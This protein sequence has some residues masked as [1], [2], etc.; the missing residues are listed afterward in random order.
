M[1]MRV[2]V[3]A[4][5]PSLCAAG[6]VGIRQISRPVS[7]RRKVMR[8]AFLCTIVLNRIATN[9]LLAEESAH[10]H[11]PEGFVVV[12]SSISPD[13]TYG[14]TAFDNAHYPIPKEIGANELVNLHTG[15]VCGPIDGWG[16][17][18]MNRGGIQPTR[19]SRD[20]SFLLWEVEGRWSPDALTLVRLRGCQI[21][22][23][24]NLLHVAQQAILQRTRHAAPAR[25]AT[26]KK[27]NKGSGSAFPDGFVVNVRA[28]GDK[29][30]GDP[31]ENVHGIP[32]SFPFKVHVELTSNPKELEGIGNAQLDSE[33][34][35]V[36]TADW[37][38]QVSHFQLRDKPFR[39]ATS[40]SFLQMTAPT[41]AARAPV[42]YGD[43]VTLKGRMSSRSDSTGHDVVIL[44][45]DEPI[46]IRPSD[47]APAEPSVAE[48]Q[49]L[50]LD[51][52]GGYTELA[53]KH[54]H[55]EMNGTVIRSSGSDALL[56]ISLIV[57]GYG[58]KGY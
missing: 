34:D 44:I 12:R 39:Y 3:A 20:M 19:W 6:A 53:E 1:R 16:I 45:L 50:G 22:S 43:A 42:D 40:S 35:G 52:W 55:C 5:V 2:A 14:I 54:I 32:I 30:R 11:L 29:P 49:L 8:L 21:L 28:E 41:A 51:R 58:Y 37:K 15:R 25:Y 46:S 9:S 23:Q 38:F 31:M 56:P 33:L 10:L 26:A 36:M 18:H 17:I 4:I 48:V 24:F 13:G 47:H 7:R 57:S 27:F